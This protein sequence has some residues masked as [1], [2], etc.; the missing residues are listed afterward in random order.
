MTNPLLQDWDTPFGLPPFGE[1]EVG[2]YAPAFAETM[3]EQMAEIEAIASDAQ[4]P[5]FR[6]T[7]EAMERTGR[8]LDL[9]AGVFFN[10]CASH[11]NDALQAVQ[12]EMAPKLARHQS[13]ILMNAA[14][15]QRVQ[16]V[17]D[18]GTDG[19]TPEQA[20]VLELYHRM[21]VRAGARLTGPDKERMTKIQTRLSELGTEFGLN[22][23]ADEKDWA[24][25]LDEGDL[26]GLPD[27]LTAAAAREA[28]DRGKPDKYA[29]TLS[30]SSVEPFL[31]FST[32]RNLRETAWRAWVGRGEAT[33]W[34]L[35]EETVRLRAQRAK[36]L[37]F[38]TFAAF[39]VEH[40]MAKTP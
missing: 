20:R 22:V 37:G 39:K 11:T 4:A 31:T 25:I 24:L 28:T 3:A 29:I 36:L 38:D 34:P 18:A 40:E 1:V 10:L 15:Y 33:N 26:D 2:H 13:A 23:L 8:R 21:F 5:S 6:N 35:V 12:R 19:L 7:I 14:L 16:A 27:F 9:V 32:R 30:R 17:I